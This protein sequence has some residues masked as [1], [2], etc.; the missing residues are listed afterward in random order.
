MVLQISTYTDPGVYVQEVLVPGAINV[1]GVPF[2]VGLLGVGSRQK[3][4][5]NETVLRGLVE[6]ETL[7][8]A[9][10]PPHSDQLTNRGDRKKQNT[11]VFRDGIALADSFIS[12]PAA[13]V[14]GNTLADRDFTVVNGSG[15][16]INAL[17]VSLD[18]QIPVTIRFVAQGAFATTISGT[19][20]D[21]T[22]PTASTNLAVVT[23][24]EVAAGINY[25]LSQHSSYGAAYNAV[26]QLGTTG[27]LITSPNSGSTSD[28]QILPAVF[29]FQ[30]NTT[31]AN[32]APASS[33]FGATTIRANTFVEINALVYDAAATYT[34][35]YV[36]TADADDQID[37]LANTGI[38][39]IVQVGSSAGTGNF[40]EG[41]DFQQTGDAV[42][43]TIDIAATFPAAGTDGPA[44]PFD[45]DTGA[46]GNDRIRISLDGLAAVEIDLGNLVGPPLGW[47]VPG[48]LNAA[49]AA[50]VAANINAVLGADSEYGPEYNA[51]A[52]AVLGTSGPYVR[53]TSPN[54]GTRS[55]ITFFPPTADDATAAIFG[56]Q[57]TQYPL[58]VLGIGSSPTLAANY[59]VTYEITRPTSD[60]NVQ[61]RFLNL[62]A[63]AAEIGPTTDANPLMIATELCFANGAPSVVTV[64]VDDTIPQL[65]TRQ[66][67]LDALEAIKK[68]DT[69]TEVVVL[70]TDLGTQT[71]LKTHL[72]TESSPTAKHY[73]RGWY[74]MAINTPPGDRDTSGTFVHLATQTLQV[75]PL[76]PARGR[77][78]VVAPPQQAGVSR[79]LTLEDGSTTTVNLDSTYLAAAIAAKMTSF[80][81]PA[82]S[83]VRQ[84]ITGINLRDI[85]AA[86]SPAERAI[87]AK[88]GV[89]VVTFDAGN[90]I[91]LDP[92]TTEVGG[93]GVVQ[94]AQISAGTQ[95]DNVT[96][97]VTAALDANI[98][99]IV[100][101][102]LAD[103]LIDIKLVIQSVLTGEIGTGAIG[104]FRDQAGNTRQID[105][106]TDM[107]V[108]QDPNDPTKYFFKYFY[109]LR[110][111]A[112]RLFGEYSVDNPFF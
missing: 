65:P 102:D 77:M 80:L 48:T 83:L 44:E 81:S 31:D 52:S 57:S 4:V 25:A 23:M 90:F 92:V 59:F 72:E 32:S 33:L 88:D 15:D 78:I 86:W 42:D 82:A 60:Y 67:F 51:V 19:Q 75:G 12:F 99:G 109:F 21:L 62:D 5:T 70:S 91:L 34:I 112:L 98:V 69:V 106:V 43:W 105:I 47:K 93:G 39:S 8:L 20:I 27:L 46:A 76:S 63:A 74:G 37:D 38:G 89:T 79:A 55:S 73:R 17:V 87:M 96:R 28:V 41:T 14:E 61:K 2:T 45:L 85:T 71:D 101:T 18:G 1:A 9:G 58:T 49:T 53:L 11:T 100:P 95:K 10:A 64:Q 54:E 24:A 26:A 36:T 103:F 22:L 30:G 3:R 84:T 29:D 40:T 66:E 111:P 35:D 6:G 68:T 97:K 104:P 107:Q 94:F 50:E 56:V 13:F 7:S 110:L 16:A 108:E